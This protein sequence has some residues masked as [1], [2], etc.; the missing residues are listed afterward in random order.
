VLPWGK[1]RPHTSSS[2]STRRACC[3][4]CSSSLPALGPVSAACPAPH[5]ALQM[6]Q[7]GP[8]GVHPQS[9]EAQHPQQQQ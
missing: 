4:N 3:S 2:S 7:E 5:W 9:H 1:Q 6:P 8:V